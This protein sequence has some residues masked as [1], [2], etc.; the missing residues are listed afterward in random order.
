V[1][2]FL[3]NINVFKSSK[4]FLRS[5]CELKPNLIQALQEHWLEPP[6]Q[7]NLGVNQLK[8]VHNDFDGYGTSAMKSKV[9]N[10]VCYGR[11]FRGTGFVFSK[12][13]SLALKPCLNYKNDRVSVLE[14]TDENL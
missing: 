9:G 7:K 5:Q 1:T 3:H 13:L 8:T 14:L 10:S 12:N 6:F 11:P 2:I 4:K